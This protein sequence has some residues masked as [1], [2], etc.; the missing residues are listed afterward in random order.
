[1]DFDEIN[2][3]SVEA[4][5][6]PIVSLENG[7]I[8]GYE[9]FTRI[10]GECVSGIFKELDDRNKIWDLE[11]LCRKAILKTAAMMGIHR[12]IFIN[13]YP[14][15]EECSGSHQDYTKGL[16]E[17]YRIDPRNIVVEL[18]EG[19][20]SEKEKIL[21]DIMMLYRQHGFK[22]AL[23]NVGRAYSGLESICSLN[24][25]YIK[26]D[27]DIIRGIETNPIRQSMIKSLV[28]FSSDSGIGLTAVGV[29]TSQEL[30]TLLTLGVRFAQGDFI[31][32]VSLAPQKV[33][34]AAYS[35]II[36]YQKNLA[37]L[38]GKSAAEAKK[39]VGSKKKASNI[40]VAKELQGATDPSL[41]SGRKIGELA[42]PGITVFSDMPVTDLMI[43]FHTNDNCTIATVV[44]VDRRILGI[45]PRAFLSDLLGGQ[46]G[47]GL[48]SRKL[49]KDIMI[50][51]FITLDSSEAVEIAANKA[52]SR[53]EKSIYD[54]IVISENGIYL[55]IV[56][57]KEL[58]DSIVSVE[59]TERTREIS[60]KNRLL[61]EQQIVHEMDMR[62]AETVQKS[63]YP[64][65]APSTDEW[66]C[67]FYFRPMSSVSGDVYD[68]YYN[69]NG[70]FVGTGLFDVSGHGVASGLVGILSKYI[71]ERTF[72]QGR[73]EPL[74]TVARRF[75]EMLTK[76]KGMVE[77][78]L[79]GLFLRVKDN[80]V[81]YVNCGHTDVLV[82]TTDKSSKSEVSV[83]GGTDGAFRGMF[84]GMDGLLP[85]GCK[86]IEYHVEKDTYF[87]LYTDCLVESRNLAGD[88][89]GV[90]RL[91]HIFGNAPA[92]SSKKVLEYVLDI[93]GCFTEAVPL[94]DDLTVIVLKY[95][96]K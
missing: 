36:A 30:D 42:A 16:F 83:L 24:P 88:E 94:R 28:S 27:K 29:E 14:C 13:V 66:D 49:V 86:T 91:Q 44:D 10:D 84:L 89:L 18:T 93:F 61:Q 85:S 1:M 15:A 46:Y 62:M 41:V 52:M 43:L 59:V 5:F 75:N 45:M 11:K 77:N 90:E 6:Q 57:I 96:G 68:F 56:T 80:Q 32:E 51:D 9:A 60:R 8:L 22:V 73:K 47:F 2:R 81:E 25:D 79:T 74:E 34:P 71:A 20:Q 7:D 55:G 37:V 87:L 35:R 72:M 12:R 40:Q 58:L 64:S 31:A 54:P 53:S 76:E 33:S 17:R 70:D 39:A 19:L 50:R 26:L 23:D 95:K 4:V 38:R 67:A 21:S 3:R 78:Y 82:K 48:N 69:K 63:F 92:S 65:K